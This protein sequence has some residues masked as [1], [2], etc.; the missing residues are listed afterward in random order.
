MART[1][2]GATRMLVELTAECVTIREQGYAF[3]G[4][5]STVESWSVAAPV[6]RNRIVDGC[7]GGRRSDAAIRAALHQTGH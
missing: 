1:E 5:E 4:R 7:A 3:S 6:F 2:S